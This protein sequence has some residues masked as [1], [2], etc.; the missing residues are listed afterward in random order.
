M[1]YQSCAASPM[2][3]GRVDAAARREFAD[4]QPTV[5][6]LSQGKKSPAQGLG[7]VSFEP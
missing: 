3:P 1:V 4:L 5:A 7:Q 6:K 2:V